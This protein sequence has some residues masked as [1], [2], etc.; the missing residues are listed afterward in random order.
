MK[1]CGEAMECGTN[2]GNIRLCKSCSPN[3][4]NA[5]V[6]KSDK[7]VPKVQKLHRVGTSDIS[8]ID[9]LDFG[10]CYGG[11]DKDPQIL[12]KAD[13]K[14]SIKRL[15]EEIEK[16]YPIADMQLLCEKID[17]IFGDFE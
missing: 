9:K 12:W 13:V 1:G 3:S 8:L 2:C 5:A 4:P 16:D 6:I 14:E 15:K 11:E 7:G 17:K 10:T